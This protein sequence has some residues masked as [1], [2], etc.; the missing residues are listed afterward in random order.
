[1]TNQQAKAG[2]A[3]IQAIA[4]TIRECGS[5]P[6]GVLYAGL[7]GK[8]SLEGYN[9]IIGILKGAGLVREDESHLLHWIGG[10]ESA[11]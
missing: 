5:A 1:M 9:K 3:L 8:V 11:R 4:E 7:M 10:K 2:L 6:S